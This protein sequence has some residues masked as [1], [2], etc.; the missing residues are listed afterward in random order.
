[1]FS[2]G[3]MCW[4]ETITARI[5]FQSKEEISEKWWWRHNICDLCVQ[6]WQELASSR[7]RMS[8]SFCYK[9]SQS[10]PL[11]AANALCSALIHSPDIISL[12][13]QLTGS[14]KITETELKAHFQQLSG[15]ACV[16]SKKV[17]LGVWS[18][19]NRVTVV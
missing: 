13:S 14:F 12:A 18:E 10:L 7:G 17:T 4:S 16:F 5:R 3:S 11:G 9:I 2:T 6:I 8:E 15:F 1:V 19:R